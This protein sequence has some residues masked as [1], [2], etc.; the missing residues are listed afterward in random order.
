MSEIYDEFR[1]KVGSVMNHIYRAA[2]CTTPC[3]G[4][5]YS[6]SPMERDNGIGFE[7]HRDMKQFFQPAFEQAG[8]K[9]KF[10]SEESYPS[11]WYFSYADLNGDSIA[12]L[13]KALSSQI[14]RA[15]EVGALKALNI[16]SPPRQAA[17]IRELLKDKP[18]LRT[19]ITTR[20]EE[21][22]IER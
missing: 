7:F 5:F 6:S 1:S 16:L 9:P 17:V 22:P 14:G 4:N 19:L 8:V 3:G 12:A 18:S 15:K 21:P 2:H 11:Y 13:S 10:Y 20:T